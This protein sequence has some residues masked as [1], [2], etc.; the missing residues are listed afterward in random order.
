VVLSKIALLDLD[1]FGRPLLECAAASSLDFLSLEFTQ[2]EVRLVVYGIA[3]P[4]MLK[5]GAAHVEFHPPMLWLVGPKN[6]A[7]HLVTA[8]VIVERQ[9]WR[10]GWRIEVGTVNSR[11]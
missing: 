6:A 5:D 7:E 11:L 3:S 9:H 8:E 4:Q 2:L 10:G 1:N